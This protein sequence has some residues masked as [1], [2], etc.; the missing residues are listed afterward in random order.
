[1]TSPVPGTPDTALFST[2]S[3]KNRHLPEF[4]AATGRGRS[5][6]AQDIYSQEALDAA[7]ADCGSWV[8]PPPRF[9]ELRLCTKC[10]IK[11]KT[12]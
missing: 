6:C 3:A 5:L 2:W 7:Y 12:R 11:R 4:V 10:S 8:K 1:V 9:A